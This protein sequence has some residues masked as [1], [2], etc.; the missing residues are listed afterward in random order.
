VVWIHQA[1]NA[2]E[3]VVIASLRVRQLV[4]GCAPRVEG[5]GKKT[6][7][8]Q[9]EVLARKV[10]KIEKVAGPVKPDTRHL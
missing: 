5:T 1:E 6:G 2:F 3:F 7:I 8:A 9:R 10:M 4:D